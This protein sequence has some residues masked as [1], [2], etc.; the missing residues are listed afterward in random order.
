MSTVYAILELK[1]P[2][3]YRIQ[4][5]PH[6]H[7]KIVLFMQQVKYVRHL[8]VP[9]DAGEEAYLKRARATCISISRS[10]LSQNTTTLTSLVAS[11]CQ[12]PRGR[13]A[14]ARLPLSLPVYLAGITPGRF[15]KACHTDTTGCCLLCL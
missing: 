7:F 10:S 6:Q 3:T 4:L 5:L 12:A 13:R 8:V 15:R 14:N 11:R 9:S 1:I 2:Y